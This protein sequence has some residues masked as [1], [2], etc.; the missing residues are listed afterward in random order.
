[1]AKSCRVAV[2]GSITVAL[3]DVNDLGALGF[4][5]ERDGA[6][7]TQRLTDARMIFGGSI[8]QQKSSS[9]G[10]GDLASDGAVGTR[11][12]IPVVDLSVRRA[13]GHRLLH[14]P[15]LVQDLTEGA[16]VVRC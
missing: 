12:C 6:E 10:P 16:E 4:E 7:I 13:L 9:A 15:S 8:E 3:F 2:N 14:D 11:T 5:P 1:M